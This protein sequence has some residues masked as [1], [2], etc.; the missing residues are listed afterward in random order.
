MNLHLRALATFTLIILASSPTYGQVQAKPLIQR[1]KERNNGPDQGIASQYP[2]D[3]GI[4]RDLRVIFT[5]NFEAKDVATIAERWETVRGQNEMSLTD[6]VPEHSAGKQSL[7]MS[8]LAEKGT[9]GDLYRRLGDGYDQLFTRMYVRFAE[10]CEPIHHFGTCV[11][12][13]NPATAWP[14]VRA[15]QPTRGDKSFWVGIEPFGQKWT[16]DYYTYWCDMRGSPPKGNT[17]GNSFIHDDSLKIQRGKWTCVEVMVKMNDVGQTNG[18]LALW[19]DGRPVSHLG[20]GFPKGKWTFD[21]FKPGDS[22]DGVRWNNSKGDRE[23]FTTALGGDPF[24]GFRFRTVPELKTNFLWLYVYITK[25]TR[26]HA[27]RVW[28]D[29]VVVATEYIGPLSEK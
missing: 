22:G 17:W 13:N 3:A 10:D 25:G 12:G 11:G 19:I 7:L 8:Q 15:G 6:I 26:G 21:K 14:S 27:N 24:E 29:D 2:G 23:Y 16:W 1:L 18:E 4:G 28:F 9:G 20:E 5:E